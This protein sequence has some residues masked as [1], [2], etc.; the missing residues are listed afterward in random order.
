MKLITQTC[1]SWVKF[2]VRPDAIESSSSSP[3]WE[4]LLKVTVEKAFLGFSFGAWGK[5]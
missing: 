2:W 5:W 1:P 3:I 4:S